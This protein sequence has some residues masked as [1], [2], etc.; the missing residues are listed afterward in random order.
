M[1]GE[2]TLM[3]SMDFNRSTIHLAASLALARLDAA[4]NSYTHYHPGSLDAAALH[5]ERELAASF[6]ALTDGSTFAA[7]SPAHAAANAE[8]RSYLA[9]VISRTVVDHFVGWFPSGSAKVRTD[10]RRL[11]FDLSRSEQRG[12]GHRPLCE[13]LTALVDQVAE[14]AMDALRECC[15]GADPRARAGDVKRIK[16][17]TVALALAFAVVRVVHPKYVLE[18]PA[19]HSRF[20][21]QLSQPPAGCLYRPRGAELDLAAA[22]VAFALFPH[23][24]AAG[25]EKPNL[26]TY[27]ALVVVY[28]SSTLLP[29]QTGYAPTSTQ[30]DQ[31]FDQQPPVSEPL[32]PV[33]IVGSPLF[34]QLQEQ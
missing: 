34:K 28:P 25:T 7:P 27:R 17:A 5:L 13:Q 4:V 32:E 24:S 31:V 21:P 26:A 18:W 20:D 19:P 16:S 22:R 23:V 33:P 1:V 15:G 11:W 2:P 12:I 8:T 30:T 9:A 6:A 14:A 10:A 29:S 3:E